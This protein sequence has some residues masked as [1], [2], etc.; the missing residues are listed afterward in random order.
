MTSPSKW[1]SDV[2]VRLLACVLFRTGAGLGLGIDLP[3]PKPDPAY[4]E[5]TCLYCV[6]LKC[7]NYADRNPSSDAQLKQEASFNSATRLVCG[8]AA[9]TESEARCGAVCGYDGEIS[10]HE[11]G[12]LD[13]SRGDRE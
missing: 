1:D 7:V 10:P 13:I 5:T 11:E 8:C 12:V 3:T 2:V 9:A 4:R 6:L